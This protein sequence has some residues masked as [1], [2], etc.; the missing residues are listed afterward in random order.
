M[1]P[2]RK[3]AIIH[4]TMGSP[5]GNWFP[6]M[7]AELSKSGAE[8]IVPR[9]PTPG[10][11]TLDNWLSEF[12]KQ[13]GPIDNSSTVVGHSIG[14]VCL[15]RLLERASAPIGVSVFVAGLTGFIGIP[16]F[17]K[18]NASF[19]QEPF[20]WEA[21]RKNAGTALCF[22]GDDDPYVPLSQGLEIAENL[23]VTPRIISKGGHLN[24]DSG[25][26]TFPALL[27]ELSCGHGS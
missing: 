20:N 1:G 15:L 16:E 3:I 13:V 24:A 8:V 6:W 19:V 27:H 2:T 12:A 21:I 10:G 5:E 26:V 23:R 7:A 17:D 14:A 25:Y 11:Q 22:S 9:M 18:L 4:G